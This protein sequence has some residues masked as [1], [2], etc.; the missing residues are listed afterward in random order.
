[1]PI[2]TS[3]LISNGGEGIVTMQNNTYFDL[4]AKM[5]AQLG[6]HTLLITLTDENLRSSSETI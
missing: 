4:E 3:Y 2:T 1:L 6:K 5:T